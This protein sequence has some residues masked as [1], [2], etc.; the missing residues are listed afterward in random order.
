MPEFMNVALGGTIETLRGH[1]ESEKATDFY[2]RELHPAQ[3]PNVLFNTST[4]TI[5]GLVT[6]LLEMRGEENCLEV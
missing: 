1:I 4:T 2:T 3:A 5:T 6:N